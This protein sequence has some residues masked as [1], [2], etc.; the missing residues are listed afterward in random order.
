MPIFAL[1]L[2]NSRN[3]LKKFSFAEA[4]N[5]TAQARNSTKKD[6]KPILEAFILIVFRF[7]ANNEPI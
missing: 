4:R 2:S 3:E 1:K 6:P 5:S 7:E